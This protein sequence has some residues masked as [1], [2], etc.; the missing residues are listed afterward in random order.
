MPS[1]SKGV[2]LG[3]VSYWRFYDIMAR[4]DLAK[5]ASKHKSR[6]TKLYDTIRGDRASPL[7]DIL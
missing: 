7:S 4:P 6:N 5:E 2:A 3:G 1:R